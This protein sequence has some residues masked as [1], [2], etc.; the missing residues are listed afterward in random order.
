MSPDKNHPPK[1]A[2]VLLSWFCSDKV[3][4]TLRGDLY[5]L[6][7][8][9]S[10]R[11]GRIRANIGFIADVFSSFRPFAMKEFFRSKNSNTMSMFRNYFKV[12][13]RNLLK[14]K[15]YSSIKI[16]GLAIGVAACALITIFVIDELSHDKDYADV[17]R[18]FRLLNRWKSEEGRWA[19]HQP[20]VAPLMKE[21]YPEVEKAAR[22][23]P[24]TGWYFAG[25]NL[26]RRSDKV[27]NK[28]EEGFAYADPDLLDILDVQMVYGD[29]NSA[30]SKPNSIVISKRKADIYFPDQDP[31]GKTIIL[32]EEK[33]TVWEIGGVMENPSDKNHLP[34]D[35]YI[36]LT[37]E[38]FWEGEQ[39][40]W[41]CSNYDT[42]IKI[43]EGVDPEALQAKM[44]ETFIENYIP[45]LE[46]RGSQDV[47][48]V[49]A[50][51]V[52]DLQPVSDI[53][54]YSSDVGDRI[55]NSDIKIVYLFS[56]VAFLIL[57]LAC[58]NFINLST[59]KSSTRA[60]EV[61]LR[62][63]VGSFR[64]D[65]V[66]QF[67][68][69]SIVFTA[70]SVALGLLLAWLLT[71]YFN[72]ISGRSLQMPFDQWWLYPVAI[73]FIM[74]IGLISGIY[75]SFYLSSYRPIEVIKGEV[76]KGTKGA[77]LRSVMVVFQFSCSIVLIIASLVVY[78]QMQYIL[79]KDL[80]YDKDQ[81]V[82]IQGTNTLGDRLDLFQNELLSIPEVI[83]VSASNYLPI[84]GTKR[85]QNSFWNEGRRREDVAVGAQIWRVDDNYIETLGMNLIEGRDFEPATLRDS[86]A[87]IV[88]ETFVKELGLE[89]P[90]G[91]RI[92]NWRP[93]TIIGVVEDFHF[94]S[95]KGRIGPI[96]LALGRYG[97]IVPVKVKSTNMSETLSS[98]TKVWEDF[99]PNQPIRYTFM[100]D[101]YASM[102]ED[103]ERT[104]D[105][106]TSFSVLAI[107]VACLGLFGL[108]AFMVERRSKEICIR[109]VLG[110]SV[111]K[112]FQILTMNFMKLILIS[113]LIAIP[114]SFYLMN[115][116]LADFEYQVNLGWTV[117]FFASLIITVIALLT[118]SVESIRAA[119]VNPVK[120]LRSE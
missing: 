86:A 74:L 94:E 116:W 28:Y 107:I 91:K 101:E 77:A 87:L 73:G 40:N 75:P 20:L 1:W 11:K 90:I 95:V 97:S 114:I 32:N 31:V 105:V 36:T 48:D 62:K 120:G 27:Q 6:Y 64:A 60:K 9:R 63:V 119:N 89:D 57:L 30:L 34:F 24:Y 98:I 80:G 118:V 38:E 61:G 70:I 44:T 69:E 47:E 85:D 100:D 17:D 103:V 16:G 76:S 51:W 68:T 72:V 108:S 25:E 102:Y 71:P 50:N 21:Q 54:L 5:E 109:K 112:I 59:A 117:F 41:C 23:I 12:A 58:I 4:E 49:K 56:I 65:L 99:M 39:T 104:G 82:L 10:E 43:K 2:D 29:R 8:L 115:K 84:S 3:I 110:A 66:R 83:N 14:Y 46:A 19:A 96:A 37:G 13:W 22:L 106:F 113:L 79:N 52:Y 92:E 53:H 35:F 18:I 15:M 45:Y 78:Q 7:E 42:Y 111:R 88:N 33:E 81:V 55:K 67:L 26:V 93:W